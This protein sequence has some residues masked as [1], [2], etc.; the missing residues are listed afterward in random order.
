MKKTIKINALIPGQ[1]VVISGDVSISRVVR[2]A[3]NGLYVVERK[4]E[5]ITIERRRLAVKVY[6]QFRTGPYNACD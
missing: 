3:G 4:G 5:E 2:R 6:G 1:E